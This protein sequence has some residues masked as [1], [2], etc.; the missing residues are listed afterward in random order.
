MHLPNT[1]HRPKA[2]LFRITSCLYIYRVSFFQ[3]IKLSLAPT[4]GPIGPTF[5]SREFHLGLHFDPTPVA[6]GSRAVFTILSDCHF[7]HFQP[8]V[9]I[10]QDCSHSGAVAPVHLDRVKSSDVSY[11]MG[12]TP[13]RY[14]Q[15]EI[16]HRKPKTA[17]F[18]SGNLRM[19]TLD[20]FSR[21]RAA[22]SVIQPSEIIKIDRHCPNSYHFLEV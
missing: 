6:F 14:I 7:W 1:F 16:A 2:R 11:I 18:S 21:T 9:Y 12:W 19:F 5:G 10:V 13:K 15:Q 8:T 22:L 20:T 4:G 17:G 3:P